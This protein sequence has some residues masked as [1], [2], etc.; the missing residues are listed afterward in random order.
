M[1]ANDGILSLF[2]YLVTGSLPVAVMR[3]LRR[4]GENVHVARYLPKATGYTMDELPD[5]AVEGRLVDMFSCQG[6]SG[7]SVLEE[8]CRQRNIGTVVQAGSPW[9]YKQIAMLKERRPDLKFIDML[10]NDGPHFHSFALYGQAFD[11]VIVESRAM[12]GLLE[13]GTHGAV[14]Y[15][16]ESGV[17]LGV[18]FPLGRAIEPPT[19]QMILGYI[20]RLSPE[21]NPLGFIA[22]A[23]RVLE[24]LPWMRFAMF[25]QGP[26]EDEVKARLLNSP[27][28]DA[29]EFGGFVEHP[30]QAFRRIDVLS[31]PSLL[32]GRP[33]AIMEANACGVPV[34]GAPVGGIP[35]LINEGLNGHVVALGRT[36]RLA[37]LLA[38][39]CANPASFAALRSQSRILAEARFDRT[40][41]MDRYHRVITEVRDGTPR[42]VGVVSA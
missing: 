25:G 6:S 40:R 17:D 28:R 38:G 41:M 34:I 35:E 8:L 14:A 9:A 11:A 2:P 24:A 42:P 7:V 31:V 1:S 19:G 18:F 12:L 37:E 15:Q 39:W 22:I 13:G 16:V 30:T 4:R 27:A 36:D 20:G 10:Y 26:Q 3:D 32:D 21:K 23:E 29:I 5:F 33:A